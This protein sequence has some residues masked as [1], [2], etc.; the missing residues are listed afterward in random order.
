MF[1]WLVRSRCGKFS[2]IFF[3]FLSM[4]EEKD[5]CAYKYMKNQSICRVR[6][7]NSSSDSTKFTII[8]MA[9]TH[10]GYCMEIPVFNEKKKKYWHKELF[11]Q[12]M[13]ILISHLWIEPHELLREH[14][15]GEG[16]KH[17]FSP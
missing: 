8:R 7:T 2:L 5:I 17:G 16:L 9:M 11:D 12:E 14:L 1:P 4:T 3:N 10:M 15:L 6:A 13:E